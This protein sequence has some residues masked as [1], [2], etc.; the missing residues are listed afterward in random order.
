MEG[1]CQSPKW[2]EDSNPPKNLMVINV[3][4]DCVMKAP[5]NCWYI[6][7][8]YVWSTHKSPGLLK[9]MSTEVFIDR[10]QQPRTI[11]DAIVL[12][13][14]MGEEYLW[15]DSVCIVQKEKEL[16]EQIGQMDTIYSHAL[17]TII[18][19]A[20]K[21]VES[22]LPGVS[23]TPRDVDQ[24]TARIDDDFSL[25]QTA[26]QGPKYHLQYSRWN[27]RGWTFQER[28]LSRRILF[29]PE[30][31]VLWACDGSTWD[32][33]TVLECDKPRVEVFSHGLPCND[34][35]DDGF[36]KCSPKAYNTYIAQFSSRNLT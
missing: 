32:E 22:G 33:K 2:F 1:K 15:I 21:S 25:M 10:N 24:K 17:V 36:P 6:A 4:R 12:V 18:A 14:A 7:L 29:I 23:D 20:G 3:K 26:M 28:I 13:E 30:T 8:S 31:Q 5:Q 19:A 9:D 16:A 35:F 27:T 34:E 11:I